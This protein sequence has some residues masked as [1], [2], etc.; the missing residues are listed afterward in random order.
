MVTVSSRAFRALSI[1]MSNLRDINGSPTNKTNIVNYCMARET[2]HKKLELGTLVKLNRTHE[3]GIVVRIKINW[4]IYEGKTE[5]DP[6][7][8]GVLVR[9]KEVSAFGGG[10]TIIGEN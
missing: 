6:F 4:N 8:Y 7:C 10:L 9:G 1:N 3:Y 2:I 5:K